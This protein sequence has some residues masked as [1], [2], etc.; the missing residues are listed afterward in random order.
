VT[1]PRA[2]RSFVTTALHQLGGEALSDLA[3]LL[4]SELVTNAILHAHSE[5]SVQVSMD[6][7]VVRID[8]DDD[9]PRAPQ[10]RDYSQEATTG[11]GLA[12]FEAL[13]TAWGT[14]PKNGGKTVW[15]ELRDTVD[16]V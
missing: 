6:G 2:A 7:S 10:Q 1:S 8:V 16:I 3:E 11:R 9:S 13:S 4:V 15:F 5:V 14:R 12:L